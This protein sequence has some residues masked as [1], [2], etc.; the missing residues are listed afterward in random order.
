MRPNHVRTT[1][2]LQ[3]RGMLFNRVGE[4]AQALRILAA[5]GRSSRL[6]HDGGGECQSARV[7]GADVREQLAHGALRLDKLGGVVAHYSACSIDM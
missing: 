1:H 6:V 4:L 2:C 7:E 3:L 5:P